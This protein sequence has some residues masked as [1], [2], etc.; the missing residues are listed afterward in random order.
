MLP[1]YVGSNYKFDLEI[2]TIYAID[3]PW[4]EYSV[5]DE[6]GNLVDGVTSSTDVEVL[7]DFTTGKGTA[8]ITVWDTQIAKAA[9][10]GSTMTLTFAFKDIKGNEARAS[11]TVDIL[12]EPVISNVTPAQGAQTGENKKPTISAEISNA[13]ENASVTMTVNSEKVDAV[14][15][16]GQGHLHPSCRYGGRQGHGDCDGQACG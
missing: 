13:G 14:Y 3:N 15:A 12:D 2:D 5:R 16:D 11:Y 8:H 10:N 1:A 4:I 6:K 7:G 9:E